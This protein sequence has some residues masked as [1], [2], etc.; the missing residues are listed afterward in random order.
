MLSHMKNGTSEESV[1]SIGLFRRQ[2]LDQSQT[3]FT[4]CESIRSNVFLV[5]WFTFDQCQI[6]YI[7]FSGVRALIFGGWRLFQPFFGGKLVMGLSN[8][9]IPIKIFNFG[10]LPFWRLFIEFETSLYIRQSVPQ[11]WVGN[12]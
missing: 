1:P 9:G 2:F 7:C 10:D 5:T 4:Y 11:R 8:E 3:A 6:F 12:M